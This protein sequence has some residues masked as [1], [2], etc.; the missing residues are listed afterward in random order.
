MGLPAVV[1]FSSFLF[2]QA[3][4]AGRGGQNPGRH[5]RLRRIAL[6]KGA[7]ISDRGPVGQSNFQ[8]GRR[9]TRAYTETVGHYL[10]HAPA[11]GI[12]KSG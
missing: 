2:A 6:P 9:R 3:R 5:N 12:G 8:R 1:D 7:H 10:S 4:R 11:S